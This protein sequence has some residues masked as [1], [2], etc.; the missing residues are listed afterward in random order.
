MWRRCTCCML[1]TATGWSYDVFLSHAGESKSA[2]M[3]LHGIL[4]GRLGLKVFLDCRELHP[5]D[6]A[7]HEMVEAARKAPVGVMLLC[8]RFAKKPWPLRE[9][10]IFCEGSTLLVPAVMP[11]LTYEDI[12]QELRTAA[13]G[14]AAQQLGSVNEWRSRF[15]LVLRTTM[16]ED[17]ARH[18]P[19]DE[20]AWQHRIALGVV[21]G[22][23][24]VVKARKLPDR[25]WRGTFTQRVQ[26][27][28]GKIVDD[29]VLNELKVREVKAFKDYVFE[30]ACLSHT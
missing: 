21:R 26:G 14:E 10:K 5:G 11:K 30:L 22:L 3:A 28:V 23:L 12:K 9:L 7:P 20:A 24:G 17:L 8:T 27:A 2:A 4:E 25:A 16:V 18:P 13:E 29:T 19:G 1:A 6:D 15:E